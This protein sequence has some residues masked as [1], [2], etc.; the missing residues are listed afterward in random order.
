M[1][2][3]RTSHNYDEPTSCRRASQDYIDRINRVRLV[4]HFSY[5]YVADDA[6]P[7][8]R[9]KKFCT[10]YPNQNFYDIGR[11]K[12]KAN[13]GRL[14]TAAAAIASSASP[15]HNCC[16]LANHFEA[17]SSRGFVST[18]RRATHARTTANIVLITNCFRAFENVTPTANNLRMQVRRPP[19]YG[20]RLAFPRSARDIA[21]RCAR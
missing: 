1:L 12:R 5:R 19:V 4:I 15:T 10:R 3:L 20:A 18:K 2:Q 8:R 13:P 6:F 9:K 14:V 17:I 21:T 16:P 7:A 11:R